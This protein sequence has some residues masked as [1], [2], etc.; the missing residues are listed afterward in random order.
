MLGVLPVGV[1]AVHGWPPPPAPDARQRTCVAVYMWAVTTVGY[2]V[3]WALAMCLEEAQ[4]RN[5]LA[6]RGHFLIP[7]RLG[8]ALAHSAAAVA[9]GA[10][11]LWVALDTAVALL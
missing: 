3:P 4:R 10:H 6:R 2:L 9:V 1:G 7:T 8:R 5:F 11:V